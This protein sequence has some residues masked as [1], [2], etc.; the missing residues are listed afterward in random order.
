MK[1]PPSWH[2]FCIATDM[3]N[4][5]VIGGYDRL[6]QPTAQTQRYSVSRMT[7]SMGPNLNMARYRATATYLDGYIYTFYGMCIPKGYRFYPRNSIE[8][9]ETRSFR[10]WQLIQT[11]QELLP[12]QYTLSA[13]SLNNNE[14]LVSRQGLNGQFLN[15]LFKAE[16]N[17]LIYSKEP[18]DAL[19]GYGLL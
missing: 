19:N 5:L 2:Y 16:K 17:T 13:I 11:N 4:V 12:I 10:K 1:L 18:F 15:V 6:N 7:W 3:E 14:I 9:I 8:R